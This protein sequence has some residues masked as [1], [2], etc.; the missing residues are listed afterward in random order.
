MTAEFIERIGR[1][2]LIPVAILLCCAAL[3]SCSTT[4]TRS[5]RVLVVTDD[6][7]HTVSVRIHFGVD[8]AS[9]LPGTHAMVATVVT[10]GLSPLSDSILSFLKDK[11]ATIEMRAER[12]ALILDAT[13][14]PEAWLNIESILPSLLTARVLDGLPLDELRRVQLERL[15]ELRNAPEWIAR[16]VLWRECMPGIS[17]MP[18][19]GTDSALNAI[20]LE[21]LRRFCESHLTSGNCLVG[22][23]GP[24]SA[25]QG[26]DVYGAIVRALPKGEPKRPKSSVVQTAGLNVRIVELPE[27]DDA[28]LLVGAASTPD[29]L[30]SAAWVFALASVQQAAPGASTAGID[31]PLRAERGLT[32][33]VTFSTGLA[34]AD[35]D[36]A[37]WKTD[38]ASVAGYFTVATR[39]T[40]VNALHTLRIMIKELTDVHTAGL[41]QDEMTSM[42]AAIDK[43]ET[44]R[45]PADRMRS[46][47][48]RKYMGIEL[49]SPPRTGVPF[50]VSP[51]RARQ[52]MR[53]A[54]DPRNL[55]IVAVVPDG[56]MFA[57]QIL[58]GMTTYA[59][60]EWVNGRDIRV[61]DQEYL[62]FRPFWQAAKVSVIRSEDLFR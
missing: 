57:D 5:D 6:T 15:Q 35:A 48:A 34:H 19:E 55:W 44:T 41:T 62:S 52:L 36:G 12:E 2:A 60:P 38:D 20:T 28:Y 17:G 7:A 37:Y 45:D 53:A 8:P 26:Q 40:Y 21:N 10:E 27:V 25:N 24:V 46:L 61:K 59:Y 51:A 43:N 33:D 9:V 42:Y 50:P 31:H 4:A 14:P 22:V 18:V 29:P 13:F 23:S 39:T 49:P 54:F 30:D 56:Q 11:G 1:I 3:A 16:S 58:S 47:V 32:D